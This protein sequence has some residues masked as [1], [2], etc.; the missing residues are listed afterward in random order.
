MKIRI[1]T[2]ADFM[3][4]MGCYDPELSIWKV[5]VSRYGI[6]TTRE[7]YGFNDAY[8][9]ALA[10]VIGLKN[11]IEPQKNLKLIAEKL[12]QMEGSLGRLGQLTGFDDA[13]L[14]ELKSL[15]QSLEI[16]YDSELKTVAG[17]IVASMESM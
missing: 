7:L 14:N 16:L 4:N 9:C 17:Q 2:A 10:S 11:G 13:V 15:K 12:D 1:A 8:F 3:W 5:L 6:H